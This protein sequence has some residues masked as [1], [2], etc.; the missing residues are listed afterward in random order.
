MKTKGKQRYLWRAVDQDGKEPR[1]IVTDKLRSYD[2]SQREL[3]PEV[4]HDKRQYTNNRAEQSHQSTRVRERGMRRFKSV[5]Q[6]QRFLGVHAAVYNLFNPGRHLVSAEHYRNLREGA[7]GQ[8]A[9]VVV[10]VGRQ[11]I[12][13]SREVNLTVPKFIAKSGSN[14][15]EPCPCRIRFDRKYWQETTG[16]EKIELE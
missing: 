9:E 14:Q 15:F 3:M 11:D 8:W 12:Q 7:L 4:I 2:V 16:R 6:A 5:K 1:K 10:K 13:Y